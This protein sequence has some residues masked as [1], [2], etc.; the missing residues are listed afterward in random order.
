MIFKTNF[1]ISYSGVF[2]V[3]Q[4]MEATS[5]AEPVSP[6]G[7]CY[8]ISEKVE[9]DGLQVS[10][11]CRRGRSPSLKL[12]PAPPTAEEIL[13]VWR[14]RS[15]SVCICQG[16]GVLREFLADSGIA[17]AIFRT[18]IFSLAPRRKNNL[19][20]YI[21]FYY[22]VTKYHRFSNLK[23]CAFSISYVSGSG[24]QAQLKWMLCSGFPDAFSPY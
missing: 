20:T 13:A 12:S 16:R 1:T 8:F 22:R 17:C 24:D 2:F 18:A 14:C 5:P 21:S 15:A 19:G 11:R 7:Q 9:I 10:A 4:L 3:L 23:P 6:Q